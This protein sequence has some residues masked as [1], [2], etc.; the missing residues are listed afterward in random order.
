[1]DDDLV[2]QFVAITEASPHHA[3]QYLALT[4][5]NVEQAIQLYF[6]DP[7]LATASSASNPE[8]TQPSASSRSPRPAFANHGV[9]NISDSDEDMDDDDDPSRPL[10]NT[11]DDEEIARRMQEEMYGTTGGVESEDVRAPMQRTTETLVGPD[12]E[13]GDEEVSRMIQ[14]RVLGRRARPSRKLLQRALSLFRN[15]ANHPA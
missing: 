14:E 15:T 3:Q 1:M 2:S 13:Y 11:E 10:P 5:G 4:D 9:I 8:Q 12:I 7:N 6:E